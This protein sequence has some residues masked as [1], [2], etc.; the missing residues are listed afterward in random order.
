M[1]ASLFIGRL[2][3]MKFGSRRGRK[4]SS[5][6]RVTRAASPAP[7]YTEQLRYIVTDRHQR[8]Q[9]GVSASR[10]RAPACVFGVRRDLL[11][12]WVDRERVIMESLILAMTAN[13]S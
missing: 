5:A 10:F 4:S 8:M 11:D 2:F 12:D 9:H 1:Y 7:T 3:G 13:R 6:L